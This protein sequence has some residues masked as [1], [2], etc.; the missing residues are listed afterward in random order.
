MKAATIYE[1]G[2]G[3]PGTGDYVAGDDGEVYR[4]AST[5]SRITTHAPGV[6]N[7]IEAEVEISDWSEINEDEEPTCLAVIH[8]M[9]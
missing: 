8:P 1:Q 7:S 6:G 4:V 5:G 2:N 3:F 9:D